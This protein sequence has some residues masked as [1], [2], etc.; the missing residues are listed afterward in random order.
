MVAVL[1]HPPYLMEW[2]TKR[3]AFLQRVET[4]HILTLLQHQ[5]F[6]EARDNIEAEDKMRNAC[7]KLGSLS[8][9]CV[10]PLTGTE[11]KELP[12]NSYSHGTFLHNQL[13]S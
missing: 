2:E 12:K 5:I 8:G 10:S 7:T 9:M 3:L 11:A 13:I 6:Y 1:S 4:N